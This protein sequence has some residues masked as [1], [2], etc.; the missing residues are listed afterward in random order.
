MDNKYRAEVAQ[1]VEVIEG[2]LAGMNR[3]MQEPRSPEKVAK[4]AALCQ[5]L[6]AARD[7]A[8]LITLAEDETG[9]N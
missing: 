4:I 2:F 5:G 9:A 8:V 1:L 6:Q 3:V 7:H